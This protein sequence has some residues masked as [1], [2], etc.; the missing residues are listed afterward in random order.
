[1]LEM[2]AMCAIAANR[3]YR[4]DQTIADQSRAL[5]I[6]LTTVRIG[7][8]RRPQMCQKQSW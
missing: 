5:S 2:Y 6:A 8:H 1:M 3:T 4:G 7:E